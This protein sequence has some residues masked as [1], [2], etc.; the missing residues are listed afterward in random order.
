MFWAAAEAS[1]GET[2]PKEFLPPAEQAPPAAAESAEKQN[3][4]SS[5]RAAHNKTDEVAKGPQPVKQAPMTVA[6]QEK[7]AESSHD[8]APDSKDPT[9]EEATPKEP[10]VKDVL[11]AANENAVEPKADVLESYSTKIESDDKQ[12]VKEAEPEPEAEQPIEAPKLVEKV[13]NELKEE[14]KTVLPAEQPAPKPEV[15]KVVSMPEKVE[16]IS[17]LTKKATKQE[18]TDTT[19]QATTRFS[20]EE[21]EKATKHE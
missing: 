3:E 7:P 16:P 10:L 11:S 13:V 2:L 21:P 20:Q 8:E 18:Q 9:H 5:A 6:Q 12:A 19:A 17:K 4:A 15:E 14:Q 1:K